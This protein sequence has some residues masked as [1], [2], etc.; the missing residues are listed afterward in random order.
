MYKLCQSVSEFATP[1]SAAAP[2]CAPLKWRAA[3]CFIKA[4]PRDAWV[5]AWWVC[6]FANTLIICRIN[7]G[8]LIGF[9]ALPL[10]N[11]VLL[12]SVCAHKSR[13]RVKERHHNI[14]YAP[15]ANFLYPN[16]SIAIIDPHRYGGDHIPPMMKKRVGNFCIIRNKTINYTVFACNANISDLETNWMSFKV[17]FERE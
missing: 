14:C 11:L 15:L 1:Y 5:S 2:G 7:A 17:F 13:G 12:F 16:S 4:K 8:L 9:H 3:G 6:A 10:N